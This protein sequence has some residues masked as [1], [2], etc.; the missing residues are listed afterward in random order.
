MGE[1]KIVG[2]RVPTGGE[3]WRSGLSGL[4]PIHAPGG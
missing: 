2:P 4:G 1:L 3:H